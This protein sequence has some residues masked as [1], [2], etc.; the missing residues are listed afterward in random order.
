MFLTISTR[1]LQTIK[2]WFIG[3]R[4]F[5]KVTKGGMFFLIYAITTSNK[6]LH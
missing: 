1:N 3:I 4:A 6:I 2:S 5:R